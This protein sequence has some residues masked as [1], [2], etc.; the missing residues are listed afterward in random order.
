[1]SLMHPFKAVYNKDSKILIL[2]SFPS[3]KSREFGFYYANPQNRFWNILSAI[4]SCD[5][6]KQ[7]SNTQ[8]NQYLDIIITQNN[9]L[10]QHNIAIWDI[11]KTCNIKN[12]SDATLKHL[13]INDI[14][15]LCKDSNIKAIFANGSKTAEIYKK[16][17]N[18]NKLEFYKLPSSSSAN[19][20]YKLDHLIKEWEII[21]KFL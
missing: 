6:P 1:M 16:H 4:F 19:A 21:N 3:I 11:V 18:Y 14:S 13:D 7:E 20:K 12:S 9:F 17:C 2:G 10:L 5:I 15:E 8:E